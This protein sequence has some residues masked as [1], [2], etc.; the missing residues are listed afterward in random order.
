MFVP[1]TILWRNVTFTSVTGNIEVEEWTPAPTDRGSYMCRCSIEGHYIWEPQVYPP[2]IKGSTNPISNQ[3]Y[4]SSGLVVFVDKQ[5]PPRWTHL[6]VNGVS[7]A[8]K[9]PG[10]PEKGAAIFCTVPDPYEMNAY[11]DFRRR[12]YTHFDQ[13]LT[14]DIE[15]AIN[16]SVKVWVAGQRPG[17]K[18]LVNKIAAVEFGV[19]YYY[20][21]LVLRDKA[22]QN[23]L[24][25]EQT[26]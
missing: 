19:Q 9:E 20:A 26:P 2:T 4:A 21:H 11:K 24:K 22:K 12:M 25:Q 23:T 6:L 18:R 3:E 17:E 14:A 10:R 1:G 5:P 7:R 8:L 16:L 13:N 15:K